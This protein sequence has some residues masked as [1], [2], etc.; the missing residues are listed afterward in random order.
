MERTSLKR[1]WDISI[2]QHLRRW[3]IRQSAPVAKQLPD[4]YYRMMETKRR[5]P[6]KLEDYIP[7][8]ELDLFYVSSIRLT[9][10]LTKRMTESAFGYL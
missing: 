5:V 10:R 9:T 1:M 2:K 6:E 4:H 7:K 8:N 3:L